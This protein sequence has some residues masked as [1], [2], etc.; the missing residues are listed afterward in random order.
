MRLL[1]EFL[2]IA[3]VSTLT[4]FVL[5]KLI[6]NETWI[7]GIAIAMGLISGRLVNPLSYKNK[8]DE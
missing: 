6:S 3:I 7:M 1:L 8:K 4:V 2:T 5:Q